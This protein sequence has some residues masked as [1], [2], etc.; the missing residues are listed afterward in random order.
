MYIYKNPHGRVKIFVKN[1]AYPGYEP[2][3]EFYKVVFYKID[4]RI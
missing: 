2:I 3:N 1:C 4:L